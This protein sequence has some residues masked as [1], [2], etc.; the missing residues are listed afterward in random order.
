MKSAL[1]VWAFPDD[2]PMQRILSVTKDAGF[3]GIELVYGPSDPLNAESSEAEARALRQ[4]CLDA[5]LEV[6]SMASGI[7]WQ[8]NLISDDAQER[9]K[10]KE[11]V[12]HMLRLGA[13][14]QVDTLLVVPGSIGP[15]EAGVPTVTDYEVAYN[16]ALDDF[17]ELAADAEEAGV[18]L[19]I[20][21]VWN[22]FLTSPM[23][24]RAFV[25]AVGSPYVGVYLDV[26]NVL[27]TG[28]PEQWIRILGSRIRKVHLKDFAANIGNLSGFVS[29][30]TGDV[31]F[32][33]VMAALR[34]VGYDD[35]AVV[36]M[37]AKGDLSE[38]LVRQAA[39]DTQYILGL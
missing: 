12:Q 37:F 10:A 29:L 6:S 32:S 18:V 4:Q 16:R 30:L 20:E 2:W 19:G 3:E 11:H 31:D 24:M 25:D 15:F 33:A 35:Y 39:R 34:E 14:L 17:R 38:H 23:E 9:A 26:A 1:N 7:F 27:R 36:E 8:V 13:A 28:Y 5:G 22:K 21:T